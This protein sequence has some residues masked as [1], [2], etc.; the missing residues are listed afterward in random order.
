MRASRVVA[1]VSSLAL[2]GVFLTA[3]TPPPPTS[4][5]RLPATV[6]TTTKTIT[7]KGVPRTYLLSVPPGYTGA[8]PVPVVFDFHG[9]GSNAV[10]QDLYSRMSV[11][12]GARGWIVVTPQGQTVGST[13]LWQLATTSADVDFVAA[14][15]TGV[16]STLCVDSNRIFAA[17]ISNGAGFSGTLA[18]ALPGRFA[19]IAP[20]AG[21]NLSKPCSATTP[22]ASVIAFHGT[23]DPIV[24]YDGGLVFGALPVG[25]VPD[26]F[27]SWAAFDGCN[28]K[29]TV[30]KIASDVK[31]MDAKKCPTGIAVEL[32]TV[33]GGGHTWPGAPVDIPYGAT[34]QSIDATTLILDFFA[35]HPH[36]S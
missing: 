34:T 8:A 29:H 10:E 26:A 36:V 22:H 9:L 19:A 17:G 27:S 3:C 11:Q 7:V 14:L 16:S 13:T 28:A 12:A 33:A 24:P 15:V 35:A 2:V 6:G 31:R 20:V 1:L 32:Y 30:T 4:G 5:C 18:C 23:A 21:L 25:S